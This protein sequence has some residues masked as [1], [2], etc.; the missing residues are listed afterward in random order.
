MA[1]QNLYIKWNKDYE[2]GNLKLGNTTKR[3]GPQKN[4]IKK[5]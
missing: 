1:V 2:E 3:N 4:F 5:K